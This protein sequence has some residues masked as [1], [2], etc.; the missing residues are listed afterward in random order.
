MN[1]RSLTIMTL[2]IFP[3]LFLSSS[4]SQH[5]HQG[6]CSKDLNLTDTQK[7]QIQELKL[8]HKEEMIKLRSELQLKILELQKL[9]QSNKF[10]REDYLSA[11][12]DISAVKNKIAEQ[13]ANHHLDVYGLL[14]EKQKKEF[15]SK[16][17]KTG[18]EKCCR[19]FKKR[20]M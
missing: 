6:N 18:R 5:R 14:D 11:I 15:L 10:T 17:D 4:Y 7:V 16:G 20:D 9:E 12:K 1:Y 13:R 3:L 19:N 2:M 8:M